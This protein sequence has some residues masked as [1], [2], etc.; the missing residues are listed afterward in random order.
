MMTF[1]ELITESST[2]PEE[3]DLWDHLP[4]LG[5]G[6]AGPCEGVVLLNGLEIEMEDRCV[7]VEVESSE[8]DVILDTNDTEVEI[9]TL[10]FDI[11]VC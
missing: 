2:L 7:D 9:E 1:W 11:E 10:E 8:I 3:S 4:N 6:S 5:E